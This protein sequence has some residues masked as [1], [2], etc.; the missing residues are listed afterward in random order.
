[1][2]EEPDSSESTSTLTETSAHSDM[3]NPISLLAQEIPDLCRQC[4]V[5][6]D[7]VCR[8]CW[9]RLTG[10][11]TSIFLIRMNSPRQPAVHFHRNING[12]VFCV[13]PDAE[14]TRFT[15]QADARTAMQTHG[16][17]PLHA[18]ICLA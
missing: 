2:K 6:L 13:V 15:S 17:H 5:H 16:L 8:N 10:D 1:M 4:D 11:P 18:T 7:G 3:G 14:A 9:A 12:L